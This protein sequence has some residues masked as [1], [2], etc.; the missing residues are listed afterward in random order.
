MTCDAPSGIIPLFVRGWRVIPTLATPPASTMNYHPD[1]L[2]LHVAIPE[3][4]GEFCSHLHEDDGISHA[5][6]RGQFLRTTFFVSRHQHQ[7]RISAKVSGNGFPELLRLRL[8]LVFM[9]CAVASLEL[10]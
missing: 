1:P 3:E 5:F 4:D 9:G 6:L 2:E 8:H 7:V 10:H